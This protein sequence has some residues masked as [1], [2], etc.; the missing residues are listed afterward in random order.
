VEEVDK[1][2]MEDFLHVPIPK[3]IKDNLPLPAGLN[4]VEIPKKPE[5]MGYC[6]FTYSEKNREIP[7]THLPFPKNEKNA[8]SGRISQSV[9]H[10]GKLLPDFFGGSIVPGFFQ[11]LLM[12][13]VFFRTRT[14]FAH[15][16]ISFRFVLCEYMLIYS[17]G[18]PLERGHAFFVVSI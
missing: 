3:G 1:P 6:G 9:E 4:H 5:L 17:F 8:H 13:T 15:G 16:G 14:C 10:P 7:D 2:E 11:P 12:N 18:Q